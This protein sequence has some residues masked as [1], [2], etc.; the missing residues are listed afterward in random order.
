MYFLKLDKYCSK[1]KRFH[2]KLKRDICPKRK[3]DIFKSKKGT[4]L[5]QKNKRWGFMLYKEIHLIN[6][7]RSNISEVFI[8]NKGYISQR[9]SVKCFTGL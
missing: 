2:Y 3:T 6:T 8:S 1:F 9:F 5:R 4:L 7:K